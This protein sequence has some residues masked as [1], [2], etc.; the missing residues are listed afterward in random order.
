MPIVIRLHENHVSIEATGHE[1]N[2]IFRKILEDDRPA[3]TMPQIYVWY[4]DYAIKIILSLLSCKP[5]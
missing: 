3:D 2:Y 1:L 4:G 5:E